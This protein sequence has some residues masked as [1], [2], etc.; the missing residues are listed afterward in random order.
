MFGVSRARVTQHLNLLKL[1]S[2]IVDA[3]A[4]CEDAGIV[5][6][7]TERPLRPLTAIADPGR[8]MAEFA[9]MVAEAE[10]HRPA[11]T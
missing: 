11:W 2:A 1:P 8:V 3:L 9:A 4:E 5:G 6:Y 7:F 10:G